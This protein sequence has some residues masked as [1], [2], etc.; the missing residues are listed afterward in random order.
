MCNIQLLSLLFKIILALSTL[1]HQEQFFRKQLVLLLREKRKSTSNGIL[2]QVR[3]LKPQV[4]R[5][6]QVL[7][8]LFKS[9]TTKTE[10]SQNQVGSFLVGD[11]KPTWTVESVKEVQNPL[12]LEGTVIKGFGRGGA[13]LGCPTANLDAE[14]LSDKLA[15]ID[16]GIYFGWAQLKGE[17]YKMVTSIG[18][19]PFYKNEKKTIEPHIMHKFESDFYGEHLKIVVCGYIRPELDFVSVDALIEWIQNDIKVSDQ[20]LNQD[21]FMKFR[22]AE[23]S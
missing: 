14:S 18:W 4:T 15:T 9:M 5:F 10:T 2:M 11:G 8:P 23:S 20:A 19:N 3:T 21:R 17:T 16:P 7:K 12:I 1:S 13:E 22:F 6:L